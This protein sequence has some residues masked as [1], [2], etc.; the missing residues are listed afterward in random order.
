MSWF[1]RKPATTAEQEDPKGTKKF[2]FSFGTVTRGQLQQMMEDIL[3]DRSFVSNPLAGAEKLL[4][5]FSGHDDAAIVAESPTVQG[6]VFGTEKHEGPITYFL[7]KAVEQKEAKGEANAEL[8]SHYMKLDLM[9]RQLIEKAETARVL[10]EDPDGSKKFAFS[11]G[12]MTGSELQQRMEDILR[13]YTDIGMYAEG[14]QKVLEMVTTVPDK[15]ILM[16]SPRV[17]SVVLGGRNG[18][19]P[20]DYFLAKAREQLAGQGGEDKAPAIQVGRLEQ[21]YRQLRDEVYNQQRGVANPAEK[22]ELR[23]YRGGDDEVQR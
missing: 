4:K 2:H 21:R 7:R 1:T 5:M 15:K 3:S 23:I 13:Q 8:V 18:T 16:E 6:V 19:G 11:F 22:F 14:A 17:Q 12:T 20:V 10:K 9:Y